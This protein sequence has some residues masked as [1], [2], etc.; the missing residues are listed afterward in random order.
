MK[1]H[2]SSSCKFP[3][4]PFFWHSITA[5]ATAPAITPDSINRLP[6]ATPAPIIIPTET[7]DRTV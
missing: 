6:A 5:R 1:S 7:E 2:P 4:C 3:C